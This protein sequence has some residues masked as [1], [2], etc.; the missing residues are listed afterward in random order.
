MSTKMHIDELILL[1]LI[2][3]GIRL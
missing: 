1:L 2:F 3:H